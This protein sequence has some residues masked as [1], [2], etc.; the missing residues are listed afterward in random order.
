MSVLFKQLNLSTEFSYSLIVNF[1]IQIIGLFYSHEVVC[2]VASSV[3]KAIMWYYIVDLTMYAQTCT[4][5]TEVG[6]KL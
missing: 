6:K 5:I 1:L 4:R 3:H 2:L